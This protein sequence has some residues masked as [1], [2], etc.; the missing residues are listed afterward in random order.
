MTFGAI[1]LF[2]LALWLSNASIA[3]LAAQG[4][5][6]GP[7][8]G[9]SL[10]QPLT[11]SDLSV[12]NWPALF[13][14]VGNLATVLIV[15]GVSLLLIASEL[16]L[17]IK[18]DIDLDHELQATGVAN[19]A[20]G[21]GSGI[22][23]FH[24]LSLSTLGYKMGTPSRLI[25]LTSAVLCGVML[26]FGGSILALLPKLVLGGV[27]MYLGLTL[28]VE[29]VV[30]AWFK[31][32]KADYLVIVL[33]L[34][35]AAVFGFLQ[36]VG[37]GILVAVIMFVFNYSRVQAVKHAL[38]GSEYQSNFEHSIYHQELLQQ[39]KDEI[40]ILLLQGYIFFGTA[41]TLL[42]RIRQRVADPTKPPV[43]YLILDFALVNGLDSS[44]LVSFGK[45]KWLAQSH[46]L[47]LVFTDL[48]L[49][50]RRQLEQAGSIVEADPHNRAFSDLDH[51]L[52]WC[53][54][55]L[56]V[57]LN[58][59]KIKT[60][61]LTEQLARLLP[62]ED[63]VSRFMAY[64]EPLQT[65]AGYYLFKQGDPANGI[66]IV[67]FGQ[68][69]VL[70]E[71]PDGQTTRLRTM[72]SGTIIGE[73]GFYTGEPRSASV[74]T[75]WSSRLYRLSNEGLKKMEREEPHLAV[76]FHQFMGR[77]LANRLIHANKTVDV[78]LEQR[79]TEA[80]E[81]AVAAAPVTPRGEKVRLTVVS[82]GQEILVKS[83]PSLIIGRTK[84]RGDTRLVHIDL[85]PHH[86]RLAGV[87]RQH[88][89]LLRHIDRWSL[90]ALGSPNGTFVNDQEVAANQIVPL[91]VNDE[92]RCGQL[93]LKFE[94]EVNDD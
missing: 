92:I 80:G 33:I 30:E 42:E 62:G 84:T 44:A 68:V 81:R 7:F 55:Q 77:L 83:R 8:P 46:R 37:I 16:E 1:I 43:R 31:L 10:W 89:R 38:T 76:A 11:I 64:F 27:L 49:K 26:F 86:G 34:V 67:E 36:G 17:E 45:M 66:Y 13:D 40:Y 4:W 75:D 79:A 54:N 22:L 2:Y 74:V 5:L 87:S 41:N 12:V 6:L 65:P 56:L 58:P 19:L 25:G 91:Q 60:H 32:P 28:L 78:L 21:L 70:L 93:R 20:S 82:S 51:G 71:R 29:W 53:E 59:T 88:C 35:T 48:S 18:Q 39:R 61:A 69:T 50:L 23:G 94:G 63:D 85:G 14:Q 73:M 24:G 9:I 72:G 57:D 90:E 52:E 47:T 3:G 15:S